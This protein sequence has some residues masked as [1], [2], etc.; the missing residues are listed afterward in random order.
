M[1]EAQG[2]TRRSQLQLLFVVVG[3]AFFDIGHAPADHSNRRTD[4]QGYSAWEI[5]P[6]MTLQVDQV[7][8][9]EATL[10]F[11]WIKIKIGLTQR[12]LLR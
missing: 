6:V 4:L 2:G 7:S 11:R 8:S 1:N 3:K 10:R 12:G 9:T 5:H